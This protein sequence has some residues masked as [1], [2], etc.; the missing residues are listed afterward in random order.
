MKHG[1]DQSKAHSDGSAYMYKAAANIRWLPSLKIY[2]NLLHNSISNVFLSLN[3]KRRTKVITFTLY[4]EVQSLQKHMPNHTFYCF[5]LWAVC[6]TASRAVFLSGEEV[7][8]RENRF[9]GGWTATLGLCAY[10]CGIAFTGL[11]DFC[12][13]GVAHYS[14]QGIKI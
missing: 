14:Q 5:S 8:S 2:W 7:L 10:Q 6:F 3:G 11:P 12:H 9:C 1:S 4:D 13:V